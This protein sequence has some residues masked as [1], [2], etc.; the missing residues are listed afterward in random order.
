M[1]GTHLELRRVR[2]ILAAALESRNREKHG[3][4][5]RASR[6]GSVLDRVHK[7]L[8]AQRLACRENR[9]K[10]S[11]RVDIRPKIRS[12][13][14]GRDLRRRAQQLVDLRFETIE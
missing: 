11:A 2:L 9:T 12:N 14:H 1:I 6:F 10:A 7:N 5:S 13:S 3:Y 4:D 8:Q